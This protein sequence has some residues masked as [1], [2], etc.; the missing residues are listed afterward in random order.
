M[1]LEFT[2]HGPKDY[3]SYEEVFNELYVKIFKHLGLKGEYMTDVTIMNNEDI[4]V[5]NKY[6]RSVDRPTDVISFAFQDDE[7]EKKLKGG[8]ISL[9]QIIISYEK[10]EKQAEKDA[11]TL[12]NIVN[13]NGLNL[14][15]SIKNI[16]SSD[17][18]SNKKLMETLDQYAGALNQGLYEERL[19]ETFLTNISKFNYLL[20]VEKEINRINEVA[21]EHSASI[22]VTKILEEMSTT[23][24]YYII[25]LIEEDAARYVKN[26]SDTNRVQLRLALCSFASDPFCHAMLEAIER[27]GII[28]ANTLSEKAL[29]VKD[30]IKVIRENANVTA[31]YS[32]V[33]YIKENESK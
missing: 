33:Q 24:S 21:K 28:S 4:H 31:I 8:P 19:Y 12:E 16:A 6:Y 25:P 9:G 23:P 29:S 27:D 18:K 20:P 17:A 15:E 14:R 11:C 5:I 1:V 22:I 26:P 2:N 10:A 7:S 30:Q 3:D 13:C 32:P